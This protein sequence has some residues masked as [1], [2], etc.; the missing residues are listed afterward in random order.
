MYMD[1]KIKK[2]YANVMNKLLTKLDELM[3]DECIDKYGT[4]E[5]LPRHL[6]QDAYDN[7][8]DIEMSLSTGLFV[9]FCEWIGH[10]IY[11]LPVSP[12]NRFL[13][14]PTCPTPAME[15]GKVYFPLGNPWVGI[16]LPT[17]EHDNE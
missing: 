8:T 10:E 1:E 9:E 3:D 17:K 7:V 2:R 13:E 12:K 6:I 11:G 4:T 5:D 16:R 15:D 14:T